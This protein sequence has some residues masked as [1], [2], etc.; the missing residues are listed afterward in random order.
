MHKTCLQDLYCL[1]IC[2]QA[3]VFV[4]RC[5]CTGWSQDLS[6]G[7][8]HVQAW[9]VVLVEGLN[10]GIVSS[11]ARLPLPVC[12]ALVRKGFGWIRLWAQYGI[13]AA[14]TS[15][16]IWMLP[17]DLPAVFHISCGRELGD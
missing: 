2:H 13:S 1:L 17:T 16:A 8:V 7:C 15:E 4:L 9:D 5:P 14:G 6:V 3:A 12:P 10:D 11:W